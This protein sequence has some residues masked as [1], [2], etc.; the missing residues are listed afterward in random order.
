[1]VPACIIEIGRSYNVSATQ[2]GWLFRLSMLGFL[3]AVIFGGRYADGRGKMPSMAFGCAS[4]AVGMFLFARADSFNASLVAMV[5]TGIGGGLAE[6]LGAATI[7]D[8]Y[9]GSNRT[10]MVNLGQVVFAVGAVAGPAATARLLGMGVDWRAA[11]VG[12]AA[13][14]VAA[15]LVALVVVSTRREKPVIHHAT[16]S[17]WRI[18]LR[19]R[20]IIWLSLGIML[21]V[22]AEIGVASWIAKYLAD[23]LGAEVPLAAA[24]VATFWLGIGLGRAGV[25][26]AARRMSDVSLIGVSL[27]LGAC[28]CAG[29]LLAS[30]PMAAMVMVL[31]FGICMGPVWP[32]IISCAGGAHPAQSGTV[33]GIVAASGALGAAIIPP[34]IGRVADAASMRAGLWMCVAILVVAAILFARLRLRPH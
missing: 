34:F 8:L 6:G 24:S 23:D 1:V 4:M 14:S 29:L 32:T 25:T 20:F 11:F 13:I 27:A 3:V 30:S 17:D 10:A 28:C 18:L 33:I 22:S 19:D 26:C 5:L 31:V 7:A 2:L 16:D 15:A 9:G 12:S 21:Y